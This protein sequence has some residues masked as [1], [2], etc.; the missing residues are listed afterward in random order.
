MKNIRTSVF[1]TNSSSTHSVSFDENTTCF[2]PCPPDE[3]GYMVIE[4]REYGRA[5]ETF[6]TVYERLSYAAV[7]AKSQGTRHNK[8]LQLFEK[9]VKDY[10][11]CDE[12]VYNFT[13]NYESN[14]P[15]PMAY[16]D[17]QSNIGEAGDIETAFES[18][19]T[20]KAFLFGAES[21]FQTDSDG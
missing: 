9:V 16:I 11:K 14:S 17:H 21:Y 8:F 4:G 1:E 20:L 18:E 2:V 15:L 13:T 5:K 12:I 3:Q 7:A 19:K 6:S 10:T